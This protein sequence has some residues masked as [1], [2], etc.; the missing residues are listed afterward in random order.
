[1]I[2]RS[3][4]NVKVTNLDRLQGFRYPTPSGD[5]KNYGQIGTVSPKASELITSY[6]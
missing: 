3:V 4:L 1:M 6:T 2:L 5:Y